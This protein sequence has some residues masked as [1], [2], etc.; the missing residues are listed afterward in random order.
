M[1]ND[2]TAIRDWLT[3]ELH[4][5]FYYKRF[6]EYG[7][8]TWNALFNLWEQD[9][10][11]TLNVQPGHARIIIQSLKTRNKQSFKTESIPLDIHSEEE[12]EENV[13]EEQR[14]IKEII[15]D[16][17]N[18]EREIHVEKEEEE[19]EFNDNLSEEY[20]ID[21]ND[22]EYKQ[23]SYTVEEQKWLTQYSHKNC[24]WS[25]KQI[26]NMF[27]E[28]FSNRA[29][30]MYA[31]Q[32]KI[33]DIRRCVQS[34]TN[35]N[36]SKYKKGKRK[37]SAVAYTKYNDEQTEWLEDYTYS[38][39]HTTAEITLL[40]NERFNTHRTCNAIYRKMLK[41]KLND[42]DRNHHKRRKRTE[43]TK[44]EKDWLLMLSADG[45]SFTYE[46]ITEWFNDRFDTNRTEIAIRSKIAGMKNQTMIEANVN[47][48]E[49][50]RNSMDIRLMDS[51]TFE[52]IMDKN[53]DDTK[54][55]QCYRRKKRR[56]KHI[57]SNLNMPPPLEYCQPLLKRFKVQ[58]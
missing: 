57:E 19:Y 29:R 54:L 43:Y 16:V 48:N 30:T 12:V 28:K 45:F 31:I 39:L 14:D 47:T 18:E 6:I 51:D 27:N 2:S 40:F 49:Y 32:S 33:C 56:I 10:I 53:K 25:G 37:K 23:L 11:C 50:V 35:I 41:C 24:V 44:E 13:R 46:Q 34:N 1:S 52:K 38:V 8:D 5:G 4:F 58:S 3:T 36:S 26:T 15:K 21:N 20:S 7:Y 42:G 17:Q 55:M 9:L 22:N